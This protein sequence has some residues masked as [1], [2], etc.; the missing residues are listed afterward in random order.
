MTGLPT[1]KDPLPHDH[2]ER[3]FGQD[4]RS[5]GWQITMPIAANDDLISDEL[6][7][8]LLLSLAKRGRR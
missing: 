5:K 6:N 1:L 7:P 3:L 4:I 2:L 8:M